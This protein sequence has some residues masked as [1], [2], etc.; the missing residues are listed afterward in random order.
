[1]NKHKRQ[2]GNIRNL[3]TLSLVVNCFYKDLRDVG[4]IR[5]CKKVCV[6]VYVCVRGTSVNNL[7]RSIIE[8]SVDSGVLSEYQDLCKVPYL[9]RLTKLDYKGFI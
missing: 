8:E 3:K 6:C 5:L 2:V 7:L 9:D 1:M 4:E